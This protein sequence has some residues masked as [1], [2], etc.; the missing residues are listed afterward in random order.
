MESKTKK[1]DNPLTDEERDWHINRWIAGGFRN[2]EEQ[3]EAWLNFARAFKVTIYK[4]IA[5]G[6]INR[7]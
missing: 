5:L 1:E 3:R 7:K 6:Y 2:D 4:G